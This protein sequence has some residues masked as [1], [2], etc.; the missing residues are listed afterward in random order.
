[1]PVSLGLGGPSYSPSGA[2]ANRTLG[3]PDAPLGL[4]PR[5][6][7]VPDPYR[8]GFVQ[9]PIQKAVPYTG[10]AQSQDPNTGDVSYWDPTTGTFQTRSTGQQGFQRRLGESQQTA[11]AS[12]EAFRRFLGSLGDGGGTAPPPAPAP[13]APIG[14]PADADPT[15]AQNAAFA[16]EKDVIGQTGRGALTSLDD[17]LAGQNLTGS[18]IAANQTGEVVRGTQEEL[19]NVARDQATTAL[20]RAQAV[21]DRNYAGRLTQRGQDI[22]QQGQTE[23]YDLGRAGYGLNRL[24]TL[25]SLYSLFQRMNA[26][27]LY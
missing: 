1:M 7:G 18:S 14:S 26:P 19:G 27:G 21:A 20:Q 17:A 9:Q 6:S 15:A 11:A 25:G 12:E 23:S 16:R 5:S 8:Q 24:N 3:A 10:P 22:S 4:S 13:V 2:L